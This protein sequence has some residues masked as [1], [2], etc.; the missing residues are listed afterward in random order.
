MNERRRCRPLH[1]TNKWLTSVGLKAETEGLIIAAQDQS[2]ATRL[3]HSNI[4]KH[5]TNPLCRMCGKLDESVDHVIAGCPELA[6]TEYMNS[7]A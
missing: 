1:R 2:L 4:I 3:Y 6:K 5:G 7:E